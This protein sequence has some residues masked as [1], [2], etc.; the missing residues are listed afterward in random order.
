LTPIN[1][2]GDLAPSTAISGRRNPMRL[3]VFCGSSAGA[4]AAYAEAAHAL[5]AAIAG[6]G[7]GLV[8]GGAS[9]GLMGMVADGALSAGGE[10][11]GVLPKSMQERE[12]AH[13][14]LTELHIV[15]SMHTRKAMMADRSDGFIALPGG[16][17][18]LEEMFEIWTWGQLGY[19]RKPLGMLNVAG[20]YDPL[21]GFLDRTVTEGFVRDLHRGMLIAERD[22]EPLLDRIVAYEPP[23]VVKWIDRA[24]R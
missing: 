8:Y 18:T 22:P 10:V 15:D 6:R 13:A 1:T 19:H 17:G 3:C 2:R 14:G 12:L 20:Y 24:Q 4:Q 5:G 11:I 23:S 21:L 7:F 9:V 16:V